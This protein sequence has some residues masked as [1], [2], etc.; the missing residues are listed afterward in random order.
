LLLLACSLPHFALAATSVTTSGGT[1][2]YT[3]GNAAGVTKVDALLTVSSDSLISKAEILLSY[4]DPALADADDRLSVSPFNG[5]S[6]GSGYDTTD[7]KLTVTGLGTAATYQSVLRTVS[8]Y[9]SSQTPKTSARTATFKIYDSDGLLKSTATKS[10]S[11]TLVD[12]VPS[13]TLSDTNNAYTEGQGALVLDSGLVV[14]DP[15]SANLVE[16]ELKITSGYETGKDVLDPAQDVTK[17]LGSDGV[18]PAGLTSSFAAGTGTLT[19]SGTATVATYQALLRKCTYQN[20]AKDASNA[21]RQVTIKVKD[22]SS[23]STGSIL[24]IAF[25]AVAQAPVLTGSSTT[26]K[27]VEGNAAVNVDDSVAISDEDSTHLSS[28]E[29]RFTSGYDSGKDV[30]GY[31]GGSV[32]A[33]WDAA[34]GK[35]TLTGVQTLATYQT[36]LRSVTFNNPDESPAMGDRTV[37]FK[38]FDEPPNS[39]EPKTPSN[40]ITR[41]FTVSSVNDPPTLDCSNKPSCSDALSY[42]GLTVSLQDTAV[43]SDPDDANL[44]KAFVEIT[45]GCLSTD[46]FSTATAV[47]GILMDNGTPCVA[48]FT[49]S[50]SV[51]DYQTMLRGVQLTLATGTSFERIV[52]ITVNDGVDNSTSM[53]RYYY[54]LDNLPIPTIVSTTAPETSGGTITI[55]GTNFGPASPNLVTKVQ[56]GMSE[57]TSITVTEAYTKLTCSAPA[58]TGQDIAVVVTVGDKKSTPYASFK[59]QNPTVSSITSVPTA[60][61]TVTITGTNFGPAGSAALSASA[62]GS[63][64]VAGKAC[65]SGTVSVA[66]TKITCTQLEGTGGGKDVTVT[67]STLSSGTTGNGK[68]SYEL[69]TISTKSLGS[70]LGYTTTF[71]GSNFGLL[72]TA[73]TVTITPSAGG[74]SFA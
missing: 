6:Q 57:C 34:A 29:V 27:W 63:I 43:L 12:N 39:N 14:S 44:A 28:A 8:F 70:F 17:I 62:G 22:S 10:I 16:A 50:A 36:V 3:E 19:I 55:T 18:T 30:L 59:Y 67:V 41:T 66:H 60:G 25:T 23:Y 37:E 1:T 42:N 53:S 69:P 64:V 46:S 68:F 72:D 47:A 7:Q 45:G 71:T 26:F 54:A 33:S 49:G 31:S 35:L 65:T 61:G 13:V 51:A 2:A 15:D 11:V 4:G 48:T 40:A 9:S 74:A 20:D 58:G 38:V 32:T 52:K 56:L 5:L 73:L 24:T 21:Q